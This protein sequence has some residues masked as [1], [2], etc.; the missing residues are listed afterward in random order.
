M[1]LSRNIKFIGHQIYHVAGPQ[2]DNL[3]KID[4]IIFKT[5][6]ADLKWIEESTFKIGEWRDTMRSTYIRWAIA[7]NGLY[8]AGD[9]YKDE[10]WKSKNQFLVSAYRLENGNNP[11][12]ATIAAWDGDTASKAHLDSTNMIASYGIIDLYACFEELVF[13]FYRTYLTHVPGKFMIGPDNRA[14]RKIYNNRATDLDSWNNAWKERLDNWQ[15][16]KIYDG[17][18][19]VFLSFI[20][21][22]GLE[23]PKSYIHTN[24]GTWAETIR[25]IAILRNCLTHGE[26]K[27]PKDL[28]DLS[29]KPHGLGFNFNAGDEISLTIHHLMSIEL[30]ADQFLTA[31]N[32]SLFEK[33]E[34]KI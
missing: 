19:Q 13:D 31:L 33:G 28:A 23:K 10:S 15:R 30:F 29:K 2:I 9:K 6:K 1:S 5:D 12:K 16:K 17:L 4:N 25:E 8:V 11:I 24:P 21:L 34:K 32:L 22:S 14:I 7:I 20:A 3:P 18:D 27:I 26:T